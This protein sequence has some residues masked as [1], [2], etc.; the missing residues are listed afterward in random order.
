MLTTATLSDLHPCCALVLCL[1]ST[2]AQESVAACKQEWC[3]VQ[4]EFTKRFATLL[5]QELQDQG[6]SITG[7]CVRVWVCV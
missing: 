6:S 1:A 7:V 5:K 2:A 4:S 3:G